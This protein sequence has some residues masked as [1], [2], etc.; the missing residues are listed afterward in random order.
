MLV[1]VGTDLVSC[2]DEKNFR[3]KNKKMCN[4][5]LSGEITLLAFR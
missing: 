3:K 1:G 4:H 5:V 2:E